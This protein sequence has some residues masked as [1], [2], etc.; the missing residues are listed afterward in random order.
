MSRN[1]QITDNSTIR[2]LDQITA[3]TSLREVLSRILYRLIMVDKWE[4]FK[5][6]RGEI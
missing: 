1:K 3:V 6:K 2:N 5:I 4:G